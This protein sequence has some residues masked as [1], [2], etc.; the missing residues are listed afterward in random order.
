MKAVKT[1]EEYLSLFPEPQRKELEKIRKAIKDAAPKAEEVIS[2]GM[3]GYKLN[4][5]LVYFGG[6]KNHCSFFPAGNSAIKKFSVELKAYKTSKGT[7]QFP[8]KEPIPVSL[9]KKM[10]KERARENEIRE[11]EKASKKITTKK[12]TS[13]AV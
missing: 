5:V 7:I 3:P 8:L 4:G 13:K 2:Y 10:V 12:K 1:V 11:K 6:F 9:I